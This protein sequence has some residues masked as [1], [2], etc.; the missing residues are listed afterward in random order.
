VAAV[1]AGDELDFDHCAITVRTL[2]Y[3][4]YG[5]EEAAA[6]FRSL[7]PE[8][9]RLWSDAASVM[10]EVESQAGASSEGKQDQG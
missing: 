2:A 10:R 4:T 8:M 3:M 1:F 6:Y 7:E 5:R 9:N